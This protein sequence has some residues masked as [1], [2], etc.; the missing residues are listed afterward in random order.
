[1]QSLGSGI[2]VTTALSLGRSFLGG[3]QH[4][5]ETAGVFEALALSAVALIVAGTRDTARS[6]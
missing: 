1:M 6:A 2:P 5:N 4:A 3:P